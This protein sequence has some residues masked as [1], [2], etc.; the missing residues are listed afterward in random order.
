VLVAADTLLL[1]VAGKDA[2]GNPMT[3]TGVRY[4]SRTPGVASV[5]SL[6]GRLTGIAGGT[7]VVVASAPGGPGTVYDSLLVAVPAGGQAVAYLITNGRSFAAAR[8]G[9]TLRILTGVDLRAVP[10]EK[11][12]SYNAQ[13][14]WSTAVATFLGIGVVPVG[15]FAPPTVNTGNAGAGQVR[16]GA[17][18]PAGATPQPV[19]LAAIT[20]VAGAS[21]SSPLTFTLTDL[22]AAL[23]FTNLLTRAP[24][25]LVV[26]GAVRVQ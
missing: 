5:D 21:G 15:G 9:D 20:L 7:A 14:D 18:D 22:S 6:T 25:A 16:F 2:A 12:G 3:P 4:V 1:Q 8:V 23:T 17:A 13:F 19:G 24:A 10:G 26:S 11:L